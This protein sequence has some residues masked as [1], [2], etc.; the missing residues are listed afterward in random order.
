MNQ[1]FKRCRKLERKILKT[2]KPNGEI[3]KAFLKCVGIA[4]YNY[5]CFLIHYL[6]NWC[7]LSLPLQ[8]K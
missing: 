7:M 2:G 1:T 8:H 3:K 4:K 5:R 6:A